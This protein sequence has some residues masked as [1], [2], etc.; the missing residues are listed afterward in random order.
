LRQGGRADTECLQATAQSG[1]M[2]LQELIVWGNFPSG[3][4]TPAQPSAREQQRL[5]GASKSPPAFFAAAGTDSLIG[6]SLPS[7]M[8]CE[9]QMAVG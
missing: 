9:S 3:H 4:S 5:I 8:S 2:L 7:A 1:L 6:A